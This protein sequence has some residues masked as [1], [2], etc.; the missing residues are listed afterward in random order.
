[1]KP[2]NKDRNLSKLKAARNNKRLAKEIRR[3]AIAHSF[4]HELIENRWIIRKEK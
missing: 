3:Q 1:M 4:N 2:H